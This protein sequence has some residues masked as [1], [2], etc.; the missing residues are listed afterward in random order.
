MTE[1]FLPQLV[2][3]NFCFKTV[4]SQ[5]R[6]ERLTF[7]IWYLMCWYTQT[8]FILITLYA[9]MYFHLDDENVQ[10][11]LSWTVLSWWPNSTCR[12]KIIFEM[13]TFEGQNTKKYKCWVDIIVCLLISRHI[14]FRL[15]SVFYFKAFIGHSLQMASWYCCGTSVKASE[16]LQTF[17]FCTPD[18]YRPPPSTQINQHILNL[19]HTAALVKLTIINV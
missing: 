19:S 2:F 12:H 16:N 18:L 9:Q 11:L 15:M 13:Y 3:V 5:S 4:R 8:H 6:D 10:T 7:F 1:Q 14:N 17:D